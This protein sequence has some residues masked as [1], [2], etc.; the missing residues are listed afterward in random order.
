[1]VNQQLINIYRGLKEAASIAAKD[2]A[3]YEDA[4][5]DIYKEMDDET[6]K[7]LGDKT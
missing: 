2:A 6:R 3:R 5:D 7:A 1:M 4:A